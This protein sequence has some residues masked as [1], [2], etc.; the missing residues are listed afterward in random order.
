MDGTTLVVMS[1]SDETVMLFP[2][3]HDL[4]TQFI[5]KPNRAPPRTHTGI[6][7]WIYLLMGIMG[8][9]IVGL[10]V[11]VAV[12]LFP[13]KSNEPERAAAEN[14]SRRE[15]V[16][17]TVTPT[18]EKTVEPESPKPP[19]PPAD[20]DFKPEQP[21]L[22]TPAF[23]SPTGNWSGD[24]NSRST[25][26]TATASFTETNGKIEGQIDWNLIRT[27]NPKK[28][29]KVGSRATEYVRGSFSP[30]TGRIELR[31]YRKDDPQNIV[32]LDR[33]VLKVSADNRQISG[34]SING[35]FIL[36]R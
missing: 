23:G 34:K 20:G 14:V 33:Y 19:K 12:F 9:V 27:T 10:I 15:V 7:G 30:Q 21:V 36:R 13:D 18:A 8:T 29:D 11:L 28:I 17:E 22:P 16:S 3:G 31:G 26:F 2:S 32:I 1:N 25:A 35:N 6:P 5:S 24:W 4:P